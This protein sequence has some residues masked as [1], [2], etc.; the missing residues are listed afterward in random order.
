MDVTKVGLYY[1]ISAMSLFESW[2]NL[3]E[4]Q[5]GPIESE[6]VSINKETVNYGDE[7]NGDPELERKK[8]RS[9]ELFL[10]MLNLAR[11]ND[12]LMFQFDEIKDSVVRYINKRRELNDIAKESRENVGR[13]GQEE[14]S[15][16]E[17]RI[18]HDALI[19]N[20]NIFSR[21]CANSGKDNSWR[22]N[23]GDLRESV[24]VWADNVY[25]L[26]QKDTKF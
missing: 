25:S 11:G 7:T 17:Q 18:I 13:S 23:I 1:I 2:K 24:A 3:A 12:A 21:M 26:A 10:D 15:D 8:N 9:E 5:S 16:R 19:D 6:S 22:Q 20:L 14:H 4:E